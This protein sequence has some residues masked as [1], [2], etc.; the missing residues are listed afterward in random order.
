MDFAVF[1]PINLM[2]LY[3]KFDRLNHYSS[4]NK[5][6]SWR[7][8]ADPMSQLTFVEVHSW[9]CVS[10]L[11]S[12]MSEWSH[13]SVSHLNPEMNGSVKEKVSGLPPA[14]VARLRLWVLSIDVTW[15]L[16]WNLQQSRA[17]DSILVKYEMSYSILVK[18]EMSHLEKCA[19]CTAFYKQQN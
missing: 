14:K 3:L 8:K 7:S 9:L 18:Y 2:N 13:R 15:K 11:K 17:G 1:E 16:V 4:E 6:S 10:T 12:W 19:G 5:V